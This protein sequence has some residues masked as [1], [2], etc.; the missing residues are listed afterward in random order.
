[1]RLILMAGLALVLFATPAFAQDTVAVIEA[2]PN[3]LQQIIS[4]ISEAALPIFGGLLLLIINKVAGFIKEKFSIDIEEQHRLALHSAL[5]T[6]VRKALQAL[7]WV[8]GDPVPAGIAATAV[9]YAHKSVPDAIA[10][11]HPTE[12]VLTD[13]AESKVATATAEIVASEPV[14]APVAA[15]TATHK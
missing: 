1:M 15:K 2:Q 9:S 10:N 4:T 3:I 11:L 6:G 5:L 14:P 12:A 8:P 13:L 7:G